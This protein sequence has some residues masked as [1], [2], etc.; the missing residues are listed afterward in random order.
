VLRIILARGSREGW[1]FGPLSIAASALGLLA[2]WTLASGMWSGSLALA[3]LEFDRVAMYALALLLFGLAGRTPARVRAAIWG[4]TA[5]IWTVAL[6]AFTSRALPDLL[7]TPA[8]FDSRLSYPLTYW[9]A[10]GLLMAI[11][12]V[13]SL[14]AVA[15]AKASRLVRLLGAGSLPLLATTLLL[16]FSRGAI[17]VALLGAVGYLAIARSRTMLLA[18]LA[19]APPCAV[20]L[21]AGYDADLLGSSHFASIAAMEQGRHLAL[22]VGLST[23]GA[24]GLRAVLLPLDS[25]LTRF[26]VP[27]RRRSI[28]AAALLLGCL[29]V[30]LA[31]NLPAQVSRQYDRFLAG[32]KIASKPRERLSQAGNNGRVEHWRVA[33][34]A[35]SRHRIRGAGAGNYRYLWSRYRR[36]DFTVTDGHSLYLETLAELGV[37][38]LMLLGLALVSILCGLA[39]RARGPDRALYG[40]VLA[41]GTSWAVHAGVDWDWEMPAVTVWLFALGGLSLGREVGS[42]PRVGPPRRRWRAVCALAPGLIAVA[43]TLIAVSQA[44]L[45]EGLSAYGAGDCEQAT[46]HARASRRVLPVRAEPF[47][48][49]ALCDRQSG[50]P[51]KA[52]SATREAIER[53]PLNWELYYTLS[54]VQAEVGTDPLPAARKALRLNPRG[55]LAREGVRLFTVR[56]RNLWKVRAQTARLPF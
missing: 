18:L 26:E 25:R 13:F 15:D 5:G 19:V 6:G 47:Q 31:V 11:G 52:I 23:I 48:L 17:A 30:A 16:T 51:R 41:A 36:Q 10:L 34:D 46:E 14:H 45:D 29:I 38:G 7:S 27:R 21:H 42:A 43:A 33:L 54:L 22:V 4:L 9:N 39:I 24:V 8:T 1:A 40:A 32:E 55:P 44:R 2:V 28:A 20:A 50:K 56:D 53:D 35:F 3:L 37:V 12:I 49:E